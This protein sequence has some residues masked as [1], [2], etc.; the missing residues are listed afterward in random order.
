MLAAS[1]ASAAKERGA[2]GRFWVLPDAP[3]HWLRVTLRCPMPEPP[4]RETDRQR[5]TVM[6]EG[7]EHAQETKR[8]R[9]AADLRGGQTNR[10][11]DLLSFLCFS[12][13]FKE[14]NA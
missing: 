13:L 14:P 2:G 4:L 5:W 12:C 9:K 3:R 6:G 11:A 10:L 1:V 7:R 8:R